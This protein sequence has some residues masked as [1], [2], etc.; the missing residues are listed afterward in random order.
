MSV[1]SFMKTLGALVA[2]GVA[3]HFAGVPVWEHIGRVFHA[4]LRWLDAAVP[5][6]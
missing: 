5:V 3:M 2:G 4:A 6:L 1:D